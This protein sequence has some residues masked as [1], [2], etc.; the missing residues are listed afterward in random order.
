MVLVL[1]A[2]ALLLLL[3]VGDVGLGPAA[4]EEALVVL[5][6]AASL[7]L[8]KCKTLFLL[9]KHSTEIFNIALQSLVLALQI[10]S[11]SLMILQVSSQSGHFSVPEIDFVLLIAFLLEHQLDFLL[12]LLRFFEPLSKLSLQVINLFLKHFPVSVEG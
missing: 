2:E 9:V 10:F 12:K 5:L 1:F 6:E 4:L 8:G 3:V 11:E 7:F